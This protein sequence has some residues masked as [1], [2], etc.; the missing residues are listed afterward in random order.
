MFHSKVTLSSQA[1]MQSSGNVDYFK[2]DRNN[3]LLSDSPVSVPPDQL[4]AV[5]L[6]RTE[7][8]LI[9]SK[10]TGSTENQLVFL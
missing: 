3:P 4:C 2:L 9:L 7:L 1:D 6:Y 10:L 5:T 8:N